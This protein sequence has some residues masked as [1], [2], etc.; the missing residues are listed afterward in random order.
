MCEDVRVSGYKKAKRECVSEWQVR[1]K[2]NLKERARE[3][4]ER[5]RHNVHQRNRR[6]NLIFKVSE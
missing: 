6:E 1:A 4:E 2:T 5:P 3:N